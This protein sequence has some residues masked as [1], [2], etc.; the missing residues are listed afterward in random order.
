MTLRN[1]PG[2]IS[3]TLTV[4]L[5]AERLIAARRVSVFRRQTMLM[6]IAGVFVAVAIVMA[7]VAAYQG[8]AMVVS[9]ALAALLV[10]L[11]NLLA[12]GI[13]GFIASRAGRERELASAIE[14]RDMA[15]DALEHEV[16]GLVGELR[17]TAHE[18][19]VFA[20]DPLGAILPG[21]IGPI[22]NAL[23]ALLGGKAAQ[24]AE[25]A[26]DPAPEET[27]GLTPAPGPQTPAADPDAPFHE[28]P[29]SPPQA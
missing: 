2:N 16:D 17:G 14:M 22:L 29:A 5:R 8:L 18:L 10:A 19:R 13:L 9:P 4:L 25:A 21:A 7:N 3:R 12:A 26:A 1:T 28:D 11:G 23:L 27:D 6:V 20:R 24:A 15:Y